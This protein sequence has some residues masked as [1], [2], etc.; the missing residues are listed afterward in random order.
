ML[1]SVYFDV[2]VVLWFSMEECEALC[3][4]L[5]IMVRG[6]FVCIGETQH[7]KQKFGQGF[8]VIIKLKDVEEQ[9]DQTAAVMKVFRETFP[10][11]VLKDK[12]TVSQKYDVTSPWILEIRASI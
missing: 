8:T 4:R 7:L 5:A 3:N 2:N 11:C 1:N 9:D 12:H 10:S 6:H